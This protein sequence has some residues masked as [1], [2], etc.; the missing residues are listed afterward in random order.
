MNAVLRRR[1]GDG[2]TA[3]PWARGL[4]RGRRRTEQGRIQRA[5]DRGIAGSG[6]GGT[7][8]ARGE[9]V[10]APCRSLQ[11][12]L[13]VGWR[14]ARLRRSP[15]TTAGEDN[16]SCGLRLW[17]SSPGGMTNAARRNGCALPSGSPLDRT[18]GKH[19]AR[20]QARS[21][22]ARGGPPP[23][24]ARRPGLRPISRFPIAGW[25]DSLPTDLP[26]HG[27][28]RARG[29]RPIQVASTASHCGGGSFWA[30]RWAP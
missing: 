30:R 7:G 12:G 9:N 17:T 25:G 23:R 27:P 11:S 18:N 26:I 19:P 14:S 20:F 22:V 8:P 28:A 5:V 6:V 13:R 21:D 29:P 15:C 1:A 3:G 2:N 16:A 24:P 4:V 10:A